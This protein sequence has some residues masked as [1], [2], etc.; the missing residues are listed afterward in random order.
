MTNA[1]EGSLYESSPIRLDQKVTDK[2]IAFNNVKSVAPIGFKPV[3]FQSNNAE[4]H[5]TLPN[6]KDTFEINQQVQG[7]MIKGVLNDYDFSFYQEH[8]LE[9]EIPT[10]AQDKAYHEIL[11][12][13]KLCN[14]LSF[15]LNDTVKAFFVKNQPIQKRFIIKGIYETGLEEFDAKMVIGD[16]NLIQDLNDWGI[17]TTIDIADTLYEDHGLIVRVRTTGGNG[18]YRHDFGR[19]FNTVNSFVICPQKDTSIRVITTDFWSH[20]N[21]DLSESTLSDTCYLDIDV[22][23]HGYCE[24]QLNDFNEVE[25]N[26]TDTLGNAYTIS[27]GDREIRIHKK[28]GSGSAQNYVGAFEINIHNWDLIDKTLDDIEDLILFKPNEHQEILQVSSIRR[29]QEEIFVWLGFLDVNVIIILT[30]M[31]LIGI[32]NMGSALLVLI[33]IRSNFIGIMKAMGANNWSIRKIFLI[34][35]AHLIGRG[36]LWGNIIGLGICFAQK[37]LQLFTLNPKVYYLSKVPIEVDFWHWLLLNVGTLIVCLLALI[38]PSLVVS[39][40]EPAKTIKFD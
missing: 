17:K 33:I 29:H 4:I 40:I 30:L 10:F 5:Y 25:K 39:R 3:L 34:Q 28:D 18:N 22:D 14:D 24:I 32:I 12:S 6:G 19:G 38:I 9:G 35:A 8:L 36:M 20:L 26:Y 27:D 13:K 37:Y 11:V 2:I 21:E 23:K 7:A 15:Q 1:G 16:L 31:I